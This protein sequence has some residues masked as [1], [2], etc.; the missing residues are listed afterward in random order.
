LGTAL[1]LARL[2]SRWSATVAALRYRFVGWAEH[3]AGAT[4]DV[5][6]D[7]LPRLFV[8]FDRHVPIG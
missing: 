3:C 7:P 4:S 8:L 5:L 2:M 6:I 1:L